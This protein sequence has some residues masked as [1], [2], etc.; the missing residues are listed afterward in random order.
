MLLL[1]LPAYDYKLKHSGDNTWIFDA[2]RRK[3]VTL[4]PEEWVRQH[5]IHYLVVHLQYPKSLLAI[6][7]G[8]VYNQLGKRT[9][10]CVYSASG[11]PLML[12]EC[13]AASVPI[14]TA[15]VKQASMYN[16]MLQATY[17]VITNGLAHY[18]WQVDFKTAQNR[19]LTTIPAYSELNQ[20]P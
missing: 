19:P 7:R 9:D 14:S 3:Y 8:T 20:F 18:C 12:I 13:K 16:K 6:E 2:I 15:T 17:V 1:N 4:T 11:R 10:I 5:F